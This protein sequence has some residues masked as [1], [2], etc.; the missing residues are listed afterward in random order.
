[1]TLFKK[2][3]QKQKLKDHKNA[4]PINLEALVNSGRVRVENEELK[5]IQDKSSERKKE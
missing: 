1:M 3:I 5:K 4:K 2:I